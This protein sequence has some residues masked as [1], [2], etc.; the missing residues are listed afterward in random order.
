MKDHFSLTK[1]SK[2]FWL[3][4]KFLGSVKKH[5]QFIYLLSCCLSA[6]EVY[7]LFSEVLRRL[8][9]VEGYGI[10]CTAVTSKVDKKQGY[11]TMSTLQSTVSIIIIIR[12]YNPTNVTQ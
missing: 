1:N 5:K 2:H 10:C 12:F 3:L 4:K 11:S 9:D 7:A 6:M 8:V